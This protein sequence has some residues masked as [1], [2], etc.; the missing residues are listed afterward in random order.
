[1]LEEDFKT[2]INNLFKDIQDNTAKQVEVLKGKH[3]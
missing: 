3:C 1:M 2:G